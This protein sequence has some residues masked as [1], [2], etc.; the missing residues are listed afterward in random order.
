MKHLY[1]VRHGQSLVN[2]GGKFCTQVGTALDLGLTELGKEQAV[3]DGKKAAVAGMKFD[4]ILA[5]PLLRARE[6]AQL[7]AEQVG[8]PA[9][10]IELLDLIKEISFGELEGTDCELFYDNYTYADLN[11]FKGAET[12]EQLQ[13]RAERALEHIRQLPQDNILVV[14]HSLFGRAF[15]RVVNG[16]PYTEEFAH[17]K[18]AASLPHGEILR[19]I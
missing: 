7:I 19:L 18:H 11:E 4:L 5:S 10:K 15:R 8:Y 9:E 3:N 1:Y 6:T 13:Q 14:S 2:V 12:I 16:Q 17:G